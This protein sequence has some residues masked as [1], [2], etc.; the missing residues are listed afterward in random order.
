[1]WKWTL[2][3]TVPAMHQGCTC[4]GPGKVTVARK[5][6]N[7]RMLMKSWQT[8]HNEIWD[9]DSKE[10]WL[11]WIKRI[12]DRIFRKTLQLEIKRQIVRSMIGLLGTEEPYIFKVLAFLKWKKW[13]N[14][15]GHNSQ[16]KDRK[17]W[18]STYLTRKSL[19]IS[20]IKERAVGAA[21]QWSP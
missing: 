19:R 3:C 18:L 13:H 21:G 1:M 14:G 11:L 6:P 8:C 10:Q 12:S 7:A 17:N 20:S 15:G 2:H 4:K 16:R 9:R 5:V